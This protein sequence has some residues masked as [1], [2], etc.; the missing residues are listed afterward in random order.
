MN[1]RR[2]A[3][4]V[5]LLLLCLGA[6]LLGR[7]LRKPVTIDY[8]YLHVMPQQLAKSSGDGV[9]VLERS[10]QIHLF[11]RKDGK[12]L[13]SRPSYSA[14]GT[15][16]ST[17]GAGIITVLEGDLS[18]IRLNMD[19]GRRT[20]VTPKRETKGKFLDANLAGG[21][22]AYVVLENGDEVHVYRCDSRSETFA[23]RVARGEIRQFFLS[24]DAEFL[25]VIANTK[26]GV[27]ISVWNVVTGEKVADKEYTGVA[28]CNDRRTTGFTSDNRML[29]WMTDQTLEQYDIQL[30]RRRTIAFPS[31]FPIFCVMGPEFGF[32][33]TRWGSFDIVDTEKFEVFYSMHYENGEHPPVMGYCDWKTG[34]FTMASLQGCLYRG[35]LRLDH[36]RRL[37]DAKK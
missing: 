18:V 32:V 26:R 30:G 19:T 5:V 23:I 10:D 27:I 31:D 29:Y 33:H 7:A 13:E 20:I 25:A 12:L 15:A 24:D 36:L 3:F 6:V 16:S 21:G 9:L 8:D 11:S 14:F 35:T 22:G 28:P 4:A 1:S 2:V 17:D 34:E 37:R